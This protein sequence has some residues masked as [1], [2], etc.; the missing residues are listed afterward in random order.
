MNEVMLKGINMTYRL[1]S[2][3][4]N[5]TSTEYGP[6]SATPRMVYGTGR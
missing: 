5:N 3:D 4:S 1:D 2:R 6:V